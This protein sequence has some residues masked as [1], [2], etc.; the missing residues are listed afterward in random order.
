[1][2]IKLF[3]IS[4]DG[5]LGY[6]NH[7]YDPRNIYHKIGNFF[8]GVAPIIGVALAFYLLNIWL[9]PKMSNEIVSSL[10]SVNFAGGIAEIFNGAIN[11]VKIF[12][13]YASDGNWWLLLF[14]G[15]FLALH[16][17]LSGADIKGALSGILAYLVVMFLVNMILGF[18][19]TD[20]MN[21]L[22]SAIVGGGSFLINYLVI[23]LVLTAVAVLI[24]FVLKKL[25]RL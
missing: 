19:S 9:V 17:T 23:S 13:S 24:S 14:I 16:M 3:Q 21:G 10:N 20:L 1:M 11:T 8:I 18:I 12:F 4:G 6:V 7:S 5:T 2:E 25:F 22:T 15:I